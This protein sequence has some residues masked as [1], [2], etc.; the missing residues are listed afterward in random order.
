MP[1]NIRQKLYCYVD[2]TGQDSGSSFFVVVAVV[3]VEDRDELRQGLAEIEQAAWT[4]HRKW[5]KSRPARRLRYLDL[6]LE[7]NLTAGDVFF[8]SY[9]KPLPYFFRSSRF[10]NTPLKRKLYC[11]TMREPSWAASIAKRRGN[12]RMRCAFAG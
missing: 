6:V 4:G 10:S 12:S 7:K 5:H 1:P 3:S 8:G 9:P 11:P 2:E